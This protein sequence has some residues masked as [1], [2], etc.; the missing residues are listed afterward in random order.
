MTQENM[1]QTM[2][3]VMLLGRKRKKWT[4]KECADKIGISRTYY[5]DIENGKSFPSFE[6]IIKI[7]ELFPFFLITNDADRKKVNL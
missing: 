3:E 1:L 4:Q 6:V 2:S 7:N 5:S